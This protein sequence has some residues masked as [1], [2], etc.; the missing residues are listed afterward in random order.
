MLCKENFCRKICWKCG[1]ETSPWI[2][3]SFDI[4]VQI[5]ANAFKKLFCEK[6]IL[7]KDYQKSSIDLTLFLFPNK[8]TF[9]GHYYEKQEGSWTS[10]QSLF[11]RPNMFRSFLSLLINNL[12]NF[13]A[14]I[15][16]CS[17]DIKKITIKNLSKSFHDII[18][19]PFST[20]S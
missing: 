10:Y 9:Y 3:F 18:I 14:F 1:P 17:W 13:D 4:K 15:Q 19:I 11:R 12:A 5:T 6:D 8:G 7:K 16:K 20:F 2:L